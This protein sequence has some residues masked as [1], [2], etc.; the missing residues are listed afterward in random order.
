MSRC[1]VSAQ[2]SSVVCRSVFM[3]PR[4]TECWPTLCHLPSCVCLVPLSSSSLRASGS[5]LMAPCTSLAP[6]PSGSM[7]DSGCSVA[8]CGSGFSA[9]LC[10]SGSSTLYRAVWLWLLCSP[11]SVWLWLLCP[12][13]RC[14]AL[15]RHMTCH[16]WRGSIYFTMY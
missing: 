10:D 2:C 12:L 5:C 13:P 7:C 16:L 1:D 6:L 8:M 4:P 14:V 15:A 3:F 11:L 9:A